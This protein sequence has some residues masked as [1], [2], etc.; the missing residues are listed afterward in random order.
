VKLF[1]YPKCSTCRSAIKFLDAAGINYES[2]NIAEQ[3][4][5]IRE[6]RQM[7]K[8]QDGNVRRLFNTSGLQY[9][10][11]GLKDRMAAM[12]VD[13]A[14]ELLSGNG[15]LVKRPF[16]LSSSIGL[17]GFREEEWAVALAGP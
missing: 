15:M 17:V 13:D 11:L 8:H 5:G 4:P 12:S 7:L 16:L 3:A 6:L 14:V 1:H 9:R 2:V 10:E